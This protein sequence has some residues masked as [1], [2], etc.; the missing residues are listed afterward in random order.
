MIFAFAMISLVVAAAAALHFPALATAAIAAHPKKSRRMAEVGTCSTT[1]PLVE[2]SDTLAFSMLEEF[3]NQWLLPATPSKVRH[4]SVQLAARNSFV[5]SGFLSA[6]DEDGSASIVTNK[7]DPMGVPWQIRETRQERVVI[8]ITYRS[9]LT[10]QLQKCHL[11]MNKATDTS[12]AEF[13][14]DLAKY[15]QSD[16]G[17]IALAAKFANELLPIRI[18][19]K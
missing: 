3:R 9:V 10:S 13:V 12:R 5:F 19:S 6:S 1:T 16:T 8:E 11:V 15:A 2:F 18:D 14:G 7:R 4:C 17:N